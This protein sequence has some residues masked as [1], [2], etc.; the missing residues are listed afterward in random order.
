MA[1]TDKSQVLKPLLLGLTMI[2]TGSVNTIAAKWA[3][4]MKVDTKHFNHPFVQ[5][6][7][8]F[9][10]ELSCL[11]VYI[12][13]RYIQN[14][15]VQT[16]PY[17][18]EGSGNGIPSHISEQSFLKFNPWVFAVPAFCDVLATSIMYIGL[19]LTQ[20]SSFQMLRGAVIIFTGL[21][22]VAFLGSYL[23]GFRWLGMGFITLGLIIVG[24]SDI[25]FDENSKRDVNGIITGDLLIIIAQIIVAIQ[26]IVEQ[27][28]VTEF[29]A[30][31]LLVVGLEGLFGLAILTFLLFPMYYIKVPFIFST[32]PY[33][34]LEDIFDAFR[35][36]KSNPW[37]GCALLLT[38]ISIAFFNFTGISVTKQLSA[39]TRM[40][41]DSV[42]IL[43]IWLVSIPLF[44][45]HFI[46]LQLLG[47]AL[48]ILGMLVYN[49]I[50]FGPYLRQKILPLV[51]N[52]HLAGCCMSFWEVDLVT[53]GCSPL[54]EDSN[55]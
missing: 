18:D 51:R 13:A 43:L 46:P 42:R 28:I 49:D 25:I 33:H 19:N 35:E 7:C 39:T 29:D 20:A 10:G 24:V 27:K 44:G 23:Q 8:M 17:S 9:I 21:F 54:V 32:N 53:A 12:I 14:H 47:F 30:P 48:L 31:P 5:G 2:V 45:E 40:V 16:S 3:D 55:E 50:F 34:R 6:I 1:N 26:M 41:L 52:N 11:F 38:M 4:S 15:R 22:S 36:M 37:I